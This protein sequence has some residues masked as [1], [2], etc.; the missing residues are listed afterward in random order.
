MHD[1]LDEHQQMAVKALEELKKICDKHNIK[2]YL[3]AGSALGAVRH[4]G[5][6][7]WDDDVDVGLTHKDWY[8]LREILPRELEAPFE[9]IDND[10]DPGFP[11]LFGKIL[12]NKQSCIDLFLLAKWTGSKFSGFVH[13][14]IRRMAVEW[15]KYSLGYKPADLRINTLAKKVKITII[16]G[17]RKTAYTFVKLF[18]GRDDFIRLARWNERYFEDKNTDYYINLYS[19]YPMKKEM[20]K[21][22][23]FDHAAEVEF[24]G[25]MYLAI[26]DLDAYLTH[27]YGDYMMPPPEKARIAV[28]SEK[29]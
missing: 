15:Y 3:L 26:G 6:I 7:P 19:I 21:K 17:I 28:H 22:E 12:Y 9:Y 20:I 11:R 1:Y 4:K 2:F 5:M 14:Q 29:F 10:I 23:W 18:F 16:R 24:E 27:L 13:W 8:A 25:N